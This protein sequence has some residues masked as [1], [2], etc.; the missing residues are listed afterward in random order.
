MEHA[1]RPATQL[2]CTANSVHCPP[3][4]PPPPPKSLTFNFCHKCS[5]WLRSRGSLAVH[6]C[7]TPSETATVPHHALHMLT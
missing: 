1:P 3:P 5:C 2:V 4:P 7:G 6:Q